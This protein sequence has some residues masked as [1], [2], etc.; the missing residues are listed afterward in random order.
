MK[1]AVFV[2]LL[3]LTLGS[4]AAPALAVRVENLY[5]AV[6]PVAG[7]PRALP[8]AFRAALVEV[9][10]KVTGRRDV[11]ADDTVMSR[12]G[13]PG[14]YV[15]QYRIDDV[16]Q[17]WVRFDNV[18]L[19]RELDSVAASVWGAERP[20]TLVW[21]I[22]DDG[23]GDLRLV[24]GEPDRDGMPGLEP[25][26]DNRADP[27]VARVREELTAAAEARALPLMLPLLDAGDLASISLSDA[28]GGYTDG[29]QQASQRYETDAVLVGRARVLALGAA[30][31][32]WTLLLG[33]ERFNWDGDV[34][35]GP[36]DVADFFAARLAT[37]IGS[38]SRIVLSVDAVDSLDAYGR[39]SAYLGALDLVEELA[40]DSVNGDRVV[41]S[42]K[43]RGD[44]DHLMRSIALQRVLQPLGDD[45]R[46]R[47]PSRLGGIGNGQQ[48]LRYRLMAES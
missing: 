48:T 20:V 4:A 19:R 47:S 39:L 44:A 5:T 32:Q 40:V 38:S 12:F 2:V 18:A 14:A 28:W 16:E 15:Q 46:S 25:P 21:L 3:L 24:G 22:V 7:G 29:L 36:H 10:I 11:G 31:V 23:S 26:V 43:I 27:A 41:F 33:E 30:R 42:L 9:L 13:D 35:S 37:S 6:V 34:A 1:K 45:L 8:D 17:V